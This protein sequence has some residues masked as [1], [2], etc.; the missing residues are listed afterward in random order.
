MWCP[1]SMGLLRRVVTDVISRNHAALLS[2]GLLGA[3]WTSSGSFTTMIQALNVAYSVPETRPMWKTRLLAFELT[4]LV[5]LL[6]AIAFAFLVV[7]PHFGKFLAAESS[8]KH[9][10][11]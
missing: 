1:Q 11:S 10:L 3:L 5:G 4:F 6:V 7:G 8:R 9:S 2:L